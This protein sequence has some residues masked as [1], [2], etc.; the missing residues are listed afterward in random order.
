M[1]VIVWFLQI[2]G[3][4]LSKGDGSPRGRSDRKTETPLVDGDAINLF[5]D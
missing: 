4:R 1:K 5:D 3:C 2:P